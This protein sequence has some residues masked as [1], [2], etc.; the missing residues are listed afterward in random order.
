MGLDFFKE[1]WKNKD[2]AIWLVLIRLII[3]I[4]WFIA[5]L[6]KIIGGTFVS[7]M[8][9]TLWYF[10]NGPDPVNLGTN[11]NIW[12]VNLINNAFTPNAELFGYLVMIGEFA[13]GIALI[14]GIFVNFS[15]IVSIFMNINFIFAAGWLGASTMSVNWI[16]A[17]IGLILILSPGVKT[18][19]VDKFVANKVPVLRRFLIDWFGF[20]KLVE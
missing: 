18:L 8:P 10:I 3:G 7:D 9:N 14:F 6:Q 16:M 1:S 19:S 11:P 17:V 12:Y 5:G 15:A 20:E 13:L 2:I 4:E